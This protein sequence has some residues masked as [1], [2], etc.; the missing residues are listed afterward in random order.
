[1]ELGK[2]NIVILLYLLSGYQESKGYAALLSAP[3][4]EAGR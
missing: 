4:G 3:P 2:T 1:M